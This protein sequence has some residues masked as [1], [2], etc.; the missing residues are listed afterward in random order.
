M[1]NLCFFFPPPQY[2]G[3]PGHL[4]PQGPQGPPGRPGDPGIQGPKG[5]KGERGHGGIIGPKGSVVKYSF[6]FFFS[7]KVETTIL[8]VL[9]FNV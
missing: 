3:P 7:L 8:F 5:H 2:Q 4:G 9:L 1:W 6:V